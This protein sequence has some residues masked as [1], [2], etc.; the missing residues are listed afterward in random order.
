MSATAFL[1]MLNC[2]FML[3]AY[4]LTQFAIKSLINSDYFDV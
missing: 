3:P 2:F 1:V 4:Q